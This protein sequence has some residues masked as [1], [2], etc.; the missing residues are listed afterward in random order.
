VLECCG[1]TVNKNTLVGDK[2]AVKVGGIRVGVC[3]LTSRGMKEEEMVKV[4]EFMVNAAKRGVEIEQK[5]REGAGGKA[6]TVGE[7]G[8]VCTEDGG[9]KE[10]LK[11]VE[12]FAGG[13]FMPGE[14]LGW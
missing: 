8:K 2:S 12:G 10:M 9:V 11:E 14:E 3:A 5:M 13:Y 4:A 1:I 7:L 6:V